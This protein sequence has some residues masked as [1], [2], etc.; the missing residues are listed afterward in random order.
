MKHFERT[1]H[2]KQCL[3]DCKSVEYRTTISNSK[4]KECTLANLGSSE[5][6]TLNSK[7]DMNPPIWF[8][9]VEKEY[10][11][12]N[13]SVDFLYKQGYFSNIRS[14]VPKQKLSQFILQSEYEEVPSYDAY[15]KDIA[16]V[17]FFFGKET[18]IEFTRHRRASFAELLS[19]IGGMMGF[20]MGISMV[21]V[22]ELIFWL[23]TCLINSMR[24]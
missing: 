14:T 3:P 11:K 18:A 5:L 10:K 16:I 13:L 1:P 23:F 6:C 15:E 12:E 21:S 17:S 4:F 8:A 7:V 9:D 20:A 2:C 22:I 24:G 19:Q